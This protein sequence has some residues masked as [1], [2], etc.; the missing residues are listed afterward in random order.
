MLRHEEHVMVIPAADLPRGIVGFSDN[1]QH[2]PPLE[3]AEFRPRSAMEKDPSWKQLIPYVVVHHRS[4][5]MGKVHVL[6]YRRGVTGGESRLH[7]KRSLG[8]GGHINP[9]DAEGAAGAYEAGMR[10]EL[11]EEL[12]IECDYRIE[13]AG[14]IYDN[15]D[16]VGRVHLGIVHVLL[17]DTMDVFARE[18]CL[19]DMRFEP[20]TKVEGNV[21][22][23]ESWSQLV[24]WSLYGTGQIRGDLERMAK[25]NA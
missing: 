4:P 7:A 10:R 22:K 20:L 6:T 14:V 24:I 16:D 11:D 8:I 17:V 12:S 21:L 19:E 2:M 3:N 5:D 23:Y 15:S 13:T 18:D 9:D 25:A 1:P